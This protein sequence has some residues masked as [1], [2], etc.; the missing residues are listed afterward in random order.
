MGND[1]LSSDCTVSRPNT[2]ALKLLIRLLTPLD[3]VEDVDIRFLNNW[4]QGSALP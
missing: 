3:C 2:I 4:I 1:T